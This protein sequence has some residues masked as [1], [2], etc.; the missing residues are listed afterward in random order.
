MKAIAGTPVF[1]I[2]AAIS[3][4]RVLFQTWRN[5]ENKNTIALTTATVNA[6]TEAEN[7]KMTPKYLPV[8]GE[9]GDGNDKN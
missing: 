9:A 5:E 1:G 6:N 4:A 2:I 3:L 7:E 8:P